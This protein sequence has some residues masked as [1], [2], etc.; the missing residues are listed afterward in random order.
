MARARIYP[1]KAGSVSARELSRSLGILRL[2]Q[3]GSRF[4]PRP[5]DCIINWGASELP[6]TGC[7]VLNKPDRVV[8]ASDKVRF[9]QELNNHDSINTVPWTTNR[10]Q[11]V[12]WIQDGKTVVCRTL[13]R[14]NSGRGIVIA[15][16]ESELV[17]A[18]LYTQYV[19]KRDEYRVHVVGG[20]AIDIQRKMRSSE[21]PDESVNWQ[22]RNH[23][24]GF[25]FGRENVSLPST[26]IESAVN[27]VDAL[28]LDFG[29]VDM[30][31]NERRD[32]YYVLEVN[33]APG[34]TG[35]TLDNYRSAF[36]DLLLL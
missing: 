7:R 17:S 19:P 26:A 24:N 4:R 14:A 28:G 2:K 3:R 33:T 29:A 13:T 36:R 20:R 5:S 15:T 18:P 35:T 11:A 31:Y 10:A 32:M 25:I 9:F 1:Y 27:V 30:I 6:V 23:S 34:L 21:V 8:L 16:S 22:I 12:L